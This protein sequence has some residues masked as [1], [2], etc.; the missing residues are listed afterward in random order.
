M[1]NGYTRISEPVSEIVLCTLSSSPRDN[2]LPD[3]VA[4]CRLLVSLL[5]FGLHNISIFGYASRASAFL[6]RVPCLFRALGTA[7]HPVC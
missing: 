1:T 2:R 4:P 3:F 5:V 6:V 7:S